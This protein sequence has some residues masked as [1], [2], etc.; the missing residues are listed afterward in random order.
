MIEGLIIDSFAGGGGASTGIE[1][2]FE[3][4]FQEGLI[5]ERRFVDYAINH[6]EEAISMH[7][8]NH[9]NTEH[10]PCNI[11]QVEFDQLVSGRK[12]GLM[13]FSPDCKHFSKAK[14]GKPV[15]KNIRD[16][17]W[18]VIKAARQVRPA[19]IMLENVEEFQGWGPLIFRTD[20]DGKV[21]NDP[22]TGQ[23]QLMPCPKRKG[24][25]FRKWMAELRRLGYRAEWKELRACDYGAPTIR[26]RFFMIARRD[27]QKIAW[28][29]PTRGD[30]K[31]DAVK[32]GELKPWRTAAEIIDWSLECPSIFLTPEEVEAHYQRTG[33]R[34][35]RPLAGA[36][37]DRV[38]KGVDRYVIKAEKP[39]IV[40]L[41][42]QGGDR[43][44]PVDEP[45]NTVTG[46]HRGE[47][48]VVSPVFVGVGGRAGQSPPRS[49]EMPT[50][51][52]TAKADVAIVT[53]VLTRVAHGERDSKGKKRGRGEH[54]VAEP[55]PT[56]MASQEFS[57]T[58]PT[59]IT[60]GYGEREGQEPRVPGLENPLGTTVAG[61]I[62]HAMVA[63]H[64]MTMRNAQKPFNEAD[65][66]THTVTSMGAHL[67]LV[68]AFLAQHN[69]SYGEGHPG[70]SVTKPVSTILHTGSH[71]GLAAVHMMDMHGSDLR[72]APADSPLRA[73]T[74]GGFHAAQVAA[75]M[76]K[77]YSSDQDPRLDEPLHTATAKHRFGLV[78]VEIHGQPYII[79]DIG[80]R[81]LIPR[82]LFRA[83]GFPEGYIIDKGKI[84]V[85]NREGDREWITYEWKPLSKTAQVRMCGN[86]VCPQVAEALVWSNLIQETGSYLRSK[87]DRGAAL[88]C[89]LWPE[90]AAA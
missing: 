60:S 76:V 67:H 50:G 7:R 30:P 31:S 86:S 85:I 49:G 84:V 66:P 78:T 44:E 1:A 73:L 77:Y 81:M 37:E 29:E 35:K 88:E 34:V 83:Q 20:A 27:G 46:A 21:V 8:A 74:A 52:G 90:E 3:R 9:P 68:A 11:W 32:N 87:D 59:L 63:P 39:F 41:T 57:V 89:P 71:Q 25:T 13:W 4:A 56:Q 5:A 38:A 10:L 53:P 75:F 43:N 70:H 22:A 72:D 82:E 19:V 42:H 51:T 48:A 61:G 18:V 69:I 28:P 65:K 6:D 33:Q 40:S 17:A 80:L 36:T 47:K 45:M 58:V 24:Q 54:D 12:V 62:K 16:L 23:P 64:L 14:G 26:K 79:V 2:A 55:L 15:K